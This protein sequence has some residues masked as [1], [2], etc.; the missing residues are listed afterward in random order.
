MA[1]RR[2]FLVMVALGASSLAGACRKFGLGSLF[3][4]DQGPTLLS[5]LGHLGDIWRALSRH[6][7]G[8]VR[9]EKAYKALGKRLDK[10]LAQLRSLRERDEIG[11]ENALALATAFRERHAHIERERYVMATCYKMTALG[12]E[13]ARSR[14]VIEEQAKTLNDLVKQGKLTPEAEAKAREVIAREVAF[15]TRLRRLWYGPQGEGDY[16]SP[17]WEAERELAE[18]YGAGAIEANEA[19]AAAAKALVDFTFNRAAGRPPTPPE[20]PPVTCYAPMPPR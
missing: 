18:Q 3:A 19:S 20:P 16:T 14:G 1:T 8:A 15:Q 11:A 10:A 7:S 5:V 9:D 2:N 13:M 4:D 17:G 6:A 12:G